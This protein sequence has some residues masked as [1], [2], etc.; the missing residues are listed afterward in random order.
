MEYG[1]EIQDNDYKIQVC[2]LLEDLNYIELAYKLAK[3]IQLS[4]SPDSLKLEEVRK[5][6]RRLHSA[7]IT[8]DKI[9]I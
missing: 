8:E 5:L 9:N 4:L 1:E 6:V 7:P 2:E 3:Q